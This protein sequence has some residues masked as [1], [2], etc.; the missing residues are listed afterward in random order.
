MRAIC[1]SKSRGLLMFLMAFMLSFSLSI[2]AFAANPSQK[3]ANDAK[4]KAISVVKS[5]CSVDANGNIKYSSGLVK[6]Y[7]SEKSDS[8]HTEAVTLDGGKVVY[9]NKAGIEALAKQSDKIAANNQVGEKVNDITNN[10]TVAADTQS[11]SIMLSGFVPVVELLVGVI[12]VFIAFGMTLSSALDICYIAF[13][14]FRNKC[15]DAKQSGNAA[16]TKKSANGEVSL[17]WI[18]DDAQYAV[19]QGTIDSGKS[20]WKLYFGKR[21]A[22]YI[23][24]GVIIFILLTGNI[25]ILTDIAIKLVSGIMGVLSGLAS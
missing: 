13:P 1:R 6:Q 23:F 3:A 9:L 25:T 2:P 12:V 17:R 18:T 7:V 15:E 16:M 10:L 22:S 11:A 4:A 5:S 19:T 21:I 20:P 8:T 14:V 24:L